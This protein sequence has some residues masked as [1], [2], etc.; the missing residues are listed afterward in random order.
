MA[1]Q[2]EQLG[3]CVHPKENVVRRI[4]ILN[5]SGTRCNAS[6]RCYLCVK[7]RRMHDVHPSDVKDTGFGP[8]RT[9]HTETSSSKVDADG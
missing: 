3:R 8:W 9:F 4:R 5:K 2:S 6:E 7:E 1:K